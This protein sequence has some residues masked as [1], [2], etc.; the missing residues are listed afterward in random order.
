MSPH[1]SR[2]WR[3]LRPSYKNFHDPPRRRLD[4]QKK[5]RLQAGFLTVGSVITCPAFW[6]SVMPAASSGSTPITWEGGRE[7]GQ[8]EI[9]ETDLGLFSRTQTMC[10][11]LVFR[12]LATFQPHGNQGSS[13]RIT[14]DRA[15]QSTGHFLASFSSPAKMKQSSRS[16]EQVF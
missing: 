12:W 9:C 15:I 10:M 16:L 8:G 14:P 2:R 5:P 1:G 3:F 13:R 11:R 7:G 6:L 4:A